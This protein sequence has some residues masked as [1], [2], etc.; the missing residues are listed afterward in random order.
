MYLVLFVGC[1]HPCRLHIPQNVLRTICLKIFAT[2]NFRVALQNEN[3]KMDQKFNL[4]NYQ[5]NCIK[6]FDFLDTNNS[7]GG[8]DL[9][10]LTTIFFKISGHPLS[11]LGRFAPSLHSTTT[12]LDHFI[13]Q[14]V[15]FT[16]HTKS[17]HTST[18]KYL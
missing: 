4:H 12:P 5:K 14:R 7:Q 10:H 6:L 13:I 2:F 18:W 3:S 1:L 11:F 16:H 8:L 9:H 17:L 15:L